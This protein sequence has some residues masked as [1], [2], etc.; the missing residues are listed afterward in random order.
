MIGWYRA[1]AFAASSLLTLPSPAPRNAAPFAQADGPAGGRGAVVDGI[2]CESREADVYHAHAQLTIVHDGRVERLPLG[3]GITRRGSTPCT[4]WLHTHD[5]SGLLHIEAPHLIEPTLGA[6]FDIWGQPLTESGPADAAGSTRA[7]VDGSPWSRSLRE[8]PLR[9]GENI[10]LDVKSRASSTTPFFEEAWFARSGIRL[11]LDDGSGNI[12][13][14][15]DDQPF[16]VISATAR[17]ER[18]AVNIRSKNEDNVLDVWSAYGNVADVRHYPKVDYDVSVPRSMEQALHT[19]AGSIQLVSV[20][21]RIHADTNAGNIEGRFSGAL[22]ATLA[23]SAGGIAVDAQ[24]QTSGRIALS[25]NDGNVC[26]RASG[27]LTVD[28]AGYVEKTDLEDGYVRESPDRIVRGS[29]PWALAVA[30]SGNTGMASFRSAHPCEG[31]V[32]T[33]E[34]ELEQQQS[35]MQT[36]PHPPMQMWNP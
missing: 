20:S 7:F 23:T 4:Y 11:A 3:I 8:I 18:S 15:G 28:L 35:P 36:L 27:S 33:A 29:A 2:P 1:V 32:G 31:Y 9:D 5:A 21:G 17:G 14:R 34:W 22:D 13:V 24:P 25:T 30:L 16:V 6:L 10:V 26:L 19:S 12:S